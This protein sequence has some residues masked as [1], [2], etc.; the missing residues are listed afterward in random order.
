MS[1]LQ[2]AAVSMSLEVALG[3]PIFEFGNTVIA[4]PCIT[5]VTF[6]SKLFGRSFALREDLMGWHEAN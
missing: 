1:F 2:R 6:S 5:S 3:V 4:E